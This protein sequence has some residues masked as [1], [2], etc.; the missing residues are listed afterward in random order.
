M[1]PESTNNCV[2]RNPDL[3]IDQKKIMT[4]FF[5]AKNMHILKVVKVNYDI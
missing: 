1:F 4:C 2:K 5:F 3:I